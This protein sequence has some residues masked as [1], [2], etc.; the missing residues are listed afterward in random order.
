MEIIFHKV[1]SGLNEVT[2]VKVLGHSR[3]SLRTVLFSLVSCPPIP[4]LWRVSPLC[5]RCVAWLKAQWTLIWAPLS[6]AFVVGSWASLYHH[7]LEDY[8][9][10]LGFPDGSVGKE[11][12]Y[13]AGD[14][15]L[16][17]GLGRFPGEWNWPG[18]FHGLFSPWGHKES[19]MTEGVSFSFFEIL[20]RS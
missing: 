13:Y 12:A 6:H 9:E 20:M 10:I 8:F 14:L 19:D 1:V 4:V 16:I 7:G 2:W 5:M 11:S 17:L 15:G 3:L 18:E